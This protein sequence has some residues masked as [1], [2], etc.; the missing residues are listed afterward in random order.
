MSYVSV[1]KE[2]ALAIISL[3]QPGEKVNVLT[4]DLLDEFPRI[5][6]DIEADTGIKAAVIISSKEDNFIAGADIKMFQTVESPGEMESISREGSMLFSRIEQSEKPFVAA[7]HGS[8]MGGGLELALACHYRIATQHPKTKFALPEVQLGLLPGLGG[9]QR[10]PR[11]VGISSALDMMLTGRNIFARQAKKMGLVDEL[12]HQ[13]GLREA[14]KNVARDLAA[15]GPPKRIRGGKMPEK[16]LERTRPGRQIVYSQA[17]KKVMSQTRGNMPAPFE[18]IECVKTGIEKGMEAGLQEESV[19]FGKLAFTPQSR[20]LVR[21]YFGMQEA[22]KNPDSKKAVSVNNLGIL[23]AGLMGAG[24]ADISAQKGF[25]VVMKDRDY[26]S[27]SRGLQMVY[28]E[29]DKKVSKK[30]I[31]SFDRD[32]QLSRILPTADYAYLQNADLV[33]EAVFEDL[34][35]KR[36]VLSDIENHTN[37]SCIF[38]SNTSSLPIAD[39]AK[40][41]QR[42]EQVIG[43]HY[44]SPVQ[45]MPLLEIITTEQTADWV[46][47]TAREVGVRQGKHVIVVGDGPGFYTTRILVPFMNEALDLLQEGISIEQ[48]DSDMRDFGFPVGPAALMDEV[49]LDVG[50]HVGEVMK[51]LFDKRGTPT[52]NMAK[53]LLD[54]GYKGRKNNKGFYEYPTNK[55]KRINDEIYE[56]FGGE[57][58]K[59]FDKDEVQQRM[60]LMMVNEAVYCLQENIL[61]SPQDG[62]LGAILGL[63]FPPFRGGPFRFLDNEGAADVIDRMHTFEQ[64][65]GVRFKP[66]KLLEDKAQKKEPFYNKS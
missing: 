38:A 20:E 39:I 16:L 17:K 36:K 57:E 30:I 46:T 22:R 5:L 28:K 64:K 48:L 65:Y 61:G 54:Y 37:E 8:A 14:A 4:A 59:D 58:R 53:T 52:Q 1:S 45:K 41:A 27:A 50:A 24:I 3:D 7:I 25:N 42:P 35:I 29:L 40:N 12:I 32:Q 18:I 34:E 66:A 49:G 6:D 51:P 26:E 60:A 31:T 10:L 56:F 11:L 62:D 15:Y 23:G 13:H 19:R 47:A 63:G 9:T 33:I 55:K 2:G 21:L 44:F 43:M